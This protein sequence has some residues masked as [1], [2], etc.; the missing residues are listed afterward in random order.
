MNAPNLRGLSIKSE[1]VLSTTVDNIAPDDS[2][3]SSRSS[4]I[5]IK[6]IGKRGL[7]IRCYIPPRADLLGNKGGNTWF[8]V[9]CIHS[10]APTEQLFSNIQSTGNEEFL[11]FLSDYYEKDTKC[12]NPVPVQEKGEEKSAPSQHQPEQGDSNFSGSELEEEETMMTTP[13]AAD[14]R[15]QESTPRERPNIATLPDEGE[16][17]YSHRRPNTS[18]DEQ[19]ALEL[20]QEE[21]ERQQQQQP[22]PQGAAASG[23]GAGTPALSEEQ[24]MANIAVS[25]AGLDEEGEQKKQKKKKKKKKKG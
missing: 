16:T 2:D 18:H 25:R 22:E 13:A 20:Q 3:R 14:Q 11:T 21:L 7:Y 24:M 23:D 5:T 8:H 15:L 1:T 4:T 19:I 9:K 10:S 6:N 17:K 12:G